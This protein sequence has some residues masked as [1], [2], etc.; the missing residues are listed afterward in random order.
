M[1]YLY[2]QLKERLI[3]V[4]KAIMDNDGPYLIHC[5]AGRDRT[6]FVVLLLQSLCGCSAEQMAVDEAMAFSN[7][8]RIDKGTLEFTYVVKNTYDRNMYLMANY[9]QIPNIFEIDWN[10][11]DVTK[12]DTQKAAH[13]FCTDY[14]GLTEG[15]VSKLVDRLCK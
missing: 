8:Y 5:N 4:L 12:V 1:T 7:L 2:F 9:D 13:D 15:E 10:H 3:E 6:G 14:L 11:I